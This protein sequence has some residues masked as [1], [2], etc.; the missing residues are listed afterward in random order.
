M[1]GSHKTI[2]TQEYA[3]SYEMTMG[4]KFLGEKINE[5]YSKTIM[6]DTER[7]YSYDSKIDYTMTC[8]EKAGEPGVGL[9][10]WVTGSHDGTANLLSLHTV[11]RY[12]SLYNTPP[13]CPW[14]ACSGTSA[15]CSVCKTDWH[16]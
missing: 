1:T 9:W 6:T 14:N 15:D 7:T 4:I 13:K 5:S 8:T 16:S 11:C 12:G 3:L 2:T 10:Q